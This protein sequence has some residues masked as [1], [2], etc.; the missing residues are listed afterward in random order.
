MADFD[1]NK[2]NG[3]D[4][5]EITDNFRNPLQDTLDRIK[6]KARV[7]LCAIEATRSKRDAEELRRHNELVKTLKEAGEKGAAITVGDNAYGIQIQQNSAGALQTMENTQGLDYKKTMSVL[8][9]ISSYF[10]Y[11]QFKQTY[12]ANAENVKEMVLKTMTEVE[13]KENEGLIKKSLHLLKD[14]TVGVTGSLI[15]SGI[16]ALLGTLPI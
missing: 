8:K 3:V 9:E 10:D 14:L 15:A 2:L 7:D 13:T 11:P 1:T 4:W 16:L 5:S 6:D 12:G